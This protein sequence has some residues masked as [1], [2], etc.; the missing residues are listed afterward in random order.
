MG[1]AAWCAC[2]RV[3]GGMHL[4][5]C[6]AREVAGWAQGARPYA[7][8]PNCP[9]LHPP[10]PGVL[11]AFDKHMNLVLRDVD[12]R[13]TVLLRVQRS[14]PPLPGGCWGAPPGAGGQAGRETCAAVFGVGR[15]LN[16]S[17]F[18]IRSLGFMLPITRCPIP[19]RRQWPGAGAVGAAAG[20]PPAPVAA[21][22]CQGGQRRPG[23]CCRRC[24]SC[25]CGGGG[26]GRSVEVTLQYMKC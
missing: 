21:G 1:G 22:V 18:P 23:G 20:A 12:E 3:F 19:C 14:K 25:C 8:P 4:H 11:V 24:R 9:H 15:S 6:G 17:T 10:V 2:G 26:V 13:Y 7:H 16:D 5:A